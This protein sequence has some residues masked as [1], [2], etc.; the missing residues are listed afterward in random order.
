LGGTCWTP[1]G[2]SEPGERMSGYLTGK[3]TRI[4]RLFALIFIIGLLAFT[5]SDTA[6]AATTPAISSAKAELQALSDLVE[7]LDNELERV[8]EDYNY[9]NQQYEDA[10][11][12]S[13]KAAAAVAQAE[14]DLASARDRL[15]ERLVDIYKSGNT[16]TL[17]ALLSSETISD[18]LTLIEG[19]KSM[20]HE[21]SLLVDEIV[22][23]RNKQAELQA[24]LDASLAQLE[25]RKNQTAAAKDKVLAQLEKQK[26]ALKGKEVQLAQLR[27][28]EAERQARLAAQ[29]RAYKAFLKTRPGKVIAEAK[30]YLGV[31]YVWAGS[32]PSGFDCSGLVMYVYAKV[33]VKLPHSSYLQFRYGTPVS[34]A[35]LK[36]GDLVFFFTPIQHVGIYVG[37]GKMIN[38]TGNR[39]QISD[40]WPRSFRGGRRLL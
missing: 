23:Y 13:D 37:D 8:A 39:V 4:W 28:A 11:T 5:A 38:A 10:K 3:Q 30:K 19:F 34:R 18:A 22:T 20:A 17:D 12:E 29:L 35:N 27:K 1:G 7:R 40:V 26:K 24:K 36:P 31:H 21:D 15:A 6:S 2:Q 16:T 25:E 33:G 9:A 32:T 14:I